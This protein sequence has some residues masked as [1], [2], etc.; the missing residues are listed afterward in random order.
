MPKTLGT[1]NTDR[2]F[3]NKWRSKNGV[4]MKVTTWK[5]V[6]QFVQNLAIVGLSKSCRIVYKVQIHDMK[7]NGETKQTLMTLILTET[8]LK[9]TLV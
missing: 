3:S 5:T 9:F 4:P 7:Q 6:F 8:L 1:E 2:I